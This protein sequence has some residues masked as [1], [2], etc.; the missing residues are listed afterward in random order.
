MGL[1]AAGLQELESRAQKWR[2]ALECRLG[3]PRA[4]RAPARTPKRGRVDDCRFNFGRESANVGKNRRLN[5]RQCV[6]RPLRNARLPLSARAEAGSPSA[7]SSA[8]LFHI[9]KHGVSQ[10]PI[11]SSLIT[12]AT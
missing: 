1:G 2:E 9:L 4:I 5:R 3:G 11:G 12:P 10:K 6:P 8:L 7:C